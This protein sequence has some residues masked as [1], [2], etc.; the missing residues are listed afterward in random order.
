MATSAN[1]LAIDLHHVAKTYGR[2]VQ[3]LRGIRMQVRQ[4]E[5]FGL[6][7]PNGAG[8]TTLVKIMMTV[9]RP[10]LAKGSVLGRP[11]RRPERSQ[12]S[13]SPR[14]TAL[15]PPSLSV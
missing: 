14:V 11:V 9:I 5:I 2:K 10:T 4:G 13:F 1:D 8:K 12:R 7:G 6:L 15:R 3:A